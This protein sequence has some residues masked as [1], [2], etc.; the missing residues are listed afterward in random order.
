MTIGSHLGSA[1][2][3][4]LF[5]L[6]IDELIAHNQ[7]EVPWCMLFADDIVLVDESRDCV[8]AKLER[9]RKALESKGLKISRTKTEYMVCHFSGH[10]EKAETTMRIED[11]EIQQSDSLRNLGS[12]ISNDGEI[13]EDVEHMIKAG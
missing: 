2:S 13:N 11:Y 1:L 5:A 9:W 7:E 8:N 12:I 10:I 4:Y 3:P 6:I